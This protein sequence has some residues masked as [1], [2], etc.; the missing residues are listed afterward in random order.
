MLCDVCKKRQVKVF[1]TQIVD[2][3]M[4]EINLCT[5]CAKKEGVTDPSGFSLS[6]LLAGLTPLSINAREKDRKL[7]RVLK[8]RKNTNQKPK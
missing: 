8:K 6:D 3:K 2:G 5:P 4:Q 7:Q 1:L